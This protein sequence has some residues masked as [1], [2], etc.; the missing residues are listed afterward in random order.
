M[1]RETEVARGKR[2]VRIYDYLVRNKRK[3]ISTNEILT[4]L[5]ETDRV[6]LRNVQRDLKALVEIKDSP[7]LCSILQGKKHYF[8]Q[9]SMINKLS[10]PI[11]RNGLLAFFLI[12]RLQPFF[13]PNVKTL[14]ELSEAIMDSAGEMAYGMFED[15]DEPFEKSTFLLGDQHPLALDGDLFNDLLTSLVKRQK[16]K[17]LYQKGN[18]EKPVEKVVC[19]AKLVLFKN[20]LY[21]VCMSE[22]EGKWDFFVKLCRILKAELLEDTFTSNPKRVARIEK[23]LIE[24][25]GILDASNPKPH[26][27]VVRFP[28]DPYYKLIFIEKKY[29]NSQKISM[30]KKGNI[31][32]SMN[33]PIGID[34]VNWVLSW[35]EAVVVEPKELKEDLREVARTLTKKY[36]I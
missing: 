4:Y 10:L 25:F 5:Q 28:A 9:P 14:N 22:S 18:S 26:K 21:F 30:D 19:P 3:E 34:L 6:S 17:I 32:L 31:V 36:G 11:R 15:L 24:S 1:P 35:P 29:H 23:R 20:E 12:K 16:L 13:A 7:I 33:V 2:I 8:I 27:I